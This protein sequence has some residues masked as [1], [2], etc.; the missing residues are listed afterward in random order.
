MPVDDI[1]GLLYTAMY[2]IC[3]LIPYND[4]KSWCLEQNTLSFDIGVKDELEETDSADS[5]YFTQDYVELLVFSAYIK[6]FMPIWGLYHSVQRNNLGDEQTMINMLNVFSNPLIAEN[7]AMIRLERFADTLC[8]RRLENVS[9]ILSTELSSDEILEYGIISVLWKKVIIYDGRNSQVSLARNVYNGFKDLFN[10]LTMSGPTEKKHSSKKT[11][12]KEEESIIDGYKL[13]NRVPPGVVVAIE[14]YIKSENFMSHLN[15]NVTRSQFADM[16]SYIEGL[17]IRPSHMTICSAVCKNV[18]LI[19]DSQYID[20][21]TMRVLVAATACC[22]LDWRLPALADFIS[23]IPKVRRV[24]VASNN[25]K[26][27]KPLPK[28]LLVKASEKY[29][30]VGTTSYLQLLR[31]NLLKELV[32]YEWDFKRGKIEDFNIELYQLILRD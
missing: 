24:T 9:F 31:D 20:Y 28:E 27:L 30:V 25:G 26:P 7:A 32:C 18:L 8:K 4:F 14:T 5:T 13:I 17:D 22:L 19:Q 15:E 16:Y 6:T 2:T 10:R 23:T 3:E 29:S 12:D 1:N 21:S 11:T